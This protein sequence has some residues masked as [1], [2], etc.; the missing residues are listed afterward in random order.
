VQRVT[1]DVISDL[2]PLYAA[3]E[4]SADTRTLIEN[5]LQDDPEF[6]RTLQELVRERLPSLEVPALAPDRELE[7]L[8]R[9]RR[10]MRGPVP[11]LMFAMIFSSLAFG[12]LVSDTSFDVSPRRFIVTALIAVC[13]WAAFLFRLFKGRREVLIRVRR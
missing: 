3:G 9:V 13:F 12:A 7:T 11:L 10:R 1:R 6:A 4:A 2:W 8:T 5:F